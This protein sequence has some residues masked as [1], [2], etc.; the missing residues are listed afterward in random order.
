MDLVPVR[1]ALLSVSDKTGLAELAAA[2]VREFSVELVSTGGTARVLRAAGLPV[3]DVAE[4]T[5]WP[6]MLDGRVKTLHPAIH[7]ALLGLRDNPAHRQAMQAHHIAPLDLLVVNLYPFEQVSARAD[8]TFAEAIENIDIGGPAMIRSAAKNHRSVTVLTA[9]TQYPALLERLRRHGG[10]TDGPFRL[11]L[12]R[13]AFDRTARYDTAI[14][15]YLE[16]K[17][18]TRPGPPAHWPAAPGLAAEAPADAAPIFPPLLT[19]VLRRIQTLR[20]GEN[21]HQAGAFYSDRAT[22]TGLAAA[23]Q[24]HGKELSWINLWDAD[25]ALRLVAE[26]TRPAA[27]VI[28]HGNPCGCAEAESLAA[29]FDRAY[30]GDAAAAFGGIVAL[31]RP[32][33]A[34]AARHLIS[35]QRFLEVI[36]A[37]DFAPAALDLLRPRW[38]DCRL[39]AVALPA[40]AAGSAAAPGGGPGEWSIRSISGGVLVQQPDHRGFDRARCRVVSQRQPSAAQWDDLR[41]AWLV[42]KHVQSNAIVLAA[43]GQLLAA[44]A[45]QMSRLTSCRLA[46]DLARRNGHG[47]SLPEAVAASDAFFPFAD[48]PELLLAAGVRAIIQPGGSKKDQ[49][50]IDLC[51]RREAV[52]VFTGE[53]HFRH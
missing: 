5:G 17:S 25:A 29:A 24:L 12:A 38:K 3:R 16:R 37:P 15:A 44:G 34:P 50:T 11:Q 35:G 2:L 53:R 46:V 23:R 6:E 10:C 21:P 30:A 48:A 1:R 4:L 49:D 47:A 14:Q 18:A 33:D 28:K 36:L 51:N 20:Y 9:V 43:Q 40:T 52:L 39:L 27:A 22:P 42:C 45:G 41:F 8:S 26:F 7:G 31:N 19:T 13:E 32:V